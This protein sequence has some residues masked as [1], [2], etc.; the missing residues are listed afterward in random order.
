[1]KG[2]AE[3]E[4]EIVLPIEVS[5]GGGAAA[6]IRLKKLGG[7]GAVLVIRWIASAHA[8]GS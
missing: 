7:E 8:T 6:E 1:M 2:G 5:Q 4:G 3:P